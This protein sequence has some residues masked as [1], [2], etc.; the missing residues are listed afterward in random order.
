[1]GVRKF[2]GNG[3]GLGVW[4]GC[5]FGVGWGFGGTPL[6]VAGLSMGGMCGVVGGIGWGKGFGL[7]TQ[8]IN[9]SPEFTEGKQHRPN[10]FKQLQYVA[11]RLSTL[12]STPPPAPSGSSG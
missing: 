2:S 3:A 1:M 8:Y 12:Q 9:I 10:V 11:K 6:G 7:G 4:L 5:G